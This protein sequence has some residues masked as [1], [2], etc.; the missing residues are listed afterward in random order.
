MVQSP[1]ESDVR[2]AEEKTKNQVCECGGKELLKKKKRWARDKIARLAARC[3][4]FNSAG[5]MQRGRQRQREGRPNAR[6]L[7]GLNEKERTC[8]KLLVSQSTGYTKQSTSLSF[9]FLFLV[10]GVASCNRVSGVSMPCPN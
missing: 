7:D 4:T 2:V 10:R 6:D 8:L 3:D 1:L 5:V 9:S